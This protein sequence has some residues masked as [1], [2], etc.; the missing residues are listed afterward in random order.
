MA[1]IGGGF[2]FAA[3]GEVLETERN[4]T[5]GGLEDDED[6]SV[7]QTKDGGYILI[8]VTRSF[9]SGENDV[10]LIKIKGS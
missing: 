4:R 8:G 7:Q 1:F 5:F 6:Y 2:A 3:S 9:G 10:W